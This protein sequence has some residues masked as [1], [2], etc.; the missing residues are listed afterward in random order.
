MIR[1]IVMED[2]WDFCYLI[3]SSLK[4]EKDIKVVG[5]FH[6]AQNAVQNA[7]QLYPDII[8]ADLSLQHNQLDGIAAAR[9]LRIR[10][11]ARII[12]LSSF[13]N[14]E[15]VMKASRQTFA[16]CYLFKNQFDELAISIRRVY[17]G[18]T[19]QEFMIR[20]AV[21]AQL[22]SAESAVFQMMLGEDVQLL[23]S[24]KTI[25]NQKTS[26][27]HKLGLKNQKELQ[28]IFRNY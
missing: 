12:I 1:V 15:T 7:E 10:T 27:L 9:E 21:L 24:A 3:T 16:S 25:S 11:N 14:E 20:N 13:D 2:D 17:A 26:I 22:S 28:H 19:P 18:H 5:V 4:K 8:L 6:T 23:S